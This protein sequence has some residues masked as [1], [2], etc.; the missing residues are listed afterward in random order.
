MPA[1]FN[2]Y[3]FCP[4]TGLVRRAWFKKFQNFWKI[5]RCPFV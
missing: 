3:R 4:N 2:E 1:S 5:G